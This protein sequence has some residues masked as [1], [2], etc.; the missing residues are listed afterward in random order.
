MLLSTWFASPLLQ[1]KIFSSHLITFCCRSRDRLCDL[2]VRVPGYRSRDPGFDFRHY[3]IFLRSGGSGT[4][5]IG[6]V[7]ITEE[8]LFIYTGS[9]SP[10][11]GS[12]CDSPLKGNRTSYFDTIR[13]QREP[14]SVL[15]S[16]LKKKFVLRSILFLNIRL[17]QMWI[18]F[19][20][21]S[22][23]SLCIMQTFLLLTRFMSSGQSE[24]FTPQMTDDVSVTA[25]IPFNITSFFSCLSSILQN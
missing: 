19:P 20:H 5:P 7:N 21:F 24:Y 22:R 1:S 16:F 15:H 14:C 4:G 17:C 2:V 6:L 18:I 23:L 3:Q 11:S 9:T 10:L 25:M 13:L 8:S 12:S